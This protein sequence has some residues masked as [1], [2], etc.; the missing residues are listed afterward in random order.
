MPYRH[1]LGTRSKASIT[2]RRALTASLLLTT[3]LAWTCKMFKT[4]L[5][6][7]TRSIGAK[8]KQAIESDGCDGASLDWMLAC[9]RKAPLSNP[10]HLF[11]RY[12]NSYISFFGVGA[13]N[14][15]FYLGSALRVCMLLLLLHQF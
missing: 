10:K 8:S 1:V 13:K 4:G 9:R 14:A 11:H 15:G 3:V 12:L 5:A 7:T 6:T 2:T